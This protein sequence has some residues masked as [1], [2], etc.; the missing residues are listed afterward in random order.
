MLLKNNFF[1]VF[2][3]IYINFKSQNI[4]LNPPQIF[5]GENATV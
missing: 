4:D 2:V 5:G 3:L 1:I